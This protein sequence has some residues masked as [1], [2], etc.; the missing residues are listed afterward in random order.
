MY[1]D[2][3]SKVDR[4]EP[5]KVKRNTEERMEREREGEGLGWYK[6]RMGLSLIYLRAGELACRCVVWRE[7][8]RL[9]VDV[10][11]LGQNRS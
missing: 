6:R 5:G 9:I 7:V 4:E 8:G 3:L 11:G 10:G 1:L 2:H